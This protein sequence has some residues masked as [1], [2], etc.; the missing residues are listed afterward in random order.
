MRRPFAGK[1]GAIG[2]PRGTGGERVSVAPRRIGTGAA[3][4]LVPRPLLVYT[5]AL[6]VGDLGIGLARLAVPWVVYNLTHSAAALGV[7][8][9]AQLS[10]GWFGPLVAVAADRLDRKWAPIA[11]VAGSGLALAAI[12]LLAAGPHPPLVALVG[13]ALVQQ[14]FNALLMQSNGALRAALTPPEARVGLNTWQLTVFN[15]AWYLSPGLAGLL[16]AARGPDI[17]LWLAS[18]S[19]ILVIVPALFLPS[20]PPGPH[21]AAA[22]WRDLVEALVY[23]RADREMLWLAYFGLFWNSAWAG[24]SA[25]AVFF[26]RANLHL[27]ASAVGLLSLVAGLATT[28]VG[29]FTPGLERRLAASRVLVGTLLVSGLGMLVLALSTVWPLAALGLGAME[30]PYT[31]LEVLVT[32]T[33]QARVPHDRFARVLAMRQLIGMGGMPLMA[34]CAGG[35]AH[36]M[37]APTAIIAIGAASLLATPLVGLTPLGRLSW[38]SPTDRA[39]APA[40]AQLGTAVCARAPD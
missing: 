32:T 39:G 15:V 25:I 11:A 13:L 4:R 27:G 6:G 20:V 28:G 16:I 19:G 37:G 12:A 38:P 33:T 29:L 36:L 23:L 31:P 24:V 2:E 18:A 30:A 7:L 40:P 26:Y 8:G 1:A 34:L 35:L 5:A 22:P 14:L 10:S 9:F 17:T 3:M 21:T